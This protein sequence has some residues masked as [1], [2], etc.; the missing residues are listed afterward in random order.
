MRTYLLTY[1]LTPWSRVLPEKLTTCLQLVRKFPEYYGTR[2]FTTA[3]TKAR[4]LSLSWT[5]AIQSIP[6][7]PTSVRPILILSSHLCL[8][9][10]SSSFPEVSPLKPCM[11]LYL[12]PYALHAVPISVCLTWSPEWYLVR[13]TERNSARYCHKCDSIFISRTL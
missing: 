9:L 10:P 3:F 13:N 11:H 2:R 8:G 4:H 7:H 1:L 12:P 5:R 6:P